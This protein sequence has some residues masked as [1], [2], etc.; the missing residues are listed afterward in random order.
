MA[1]AHCQPLPRG[2]AR[3]Q[4]LGT[5][6]QGR[7]GQPASLRRTA[8]A[9]TAAE[10]GAPSGRLARWRRAAV[11][12]TVTV[13]RELALLSRAAA[14]AAAAAAWLRRRLCLRPA[15][16]VAK[17]AAKAARASRR[18]VSVAAE[19]VPAERVLE[20]GIGTQQPFFEV[21]HRSA[22]SS[23]R[24]GRLH[25]PHGVVETP[26]FVPVATHGAI[27]A[28]S[29]SDATDLGAQLV[30][31]NTLH[32]LVHPG[33]EVVAGAGGLHRFSG[34][35]GPIITDS[36]GFQLFS[37][38]A[39]SAEDGPELKCRT[40][41]RAG[42]A[43][44]SPSLLRVSE[45]GAVFRSYFD[46]THID[47]SP[48]S[49]V[50]AQKQLGSDIILPLDWLTCQGSS[51]EHLL[52]ATERSHRWMARSLAEHRR[53]P[54]GQR[55]YGILHGGTDLALR[56]RSF[57]FCAARAFDGLAIGGSLGEDRADMERLLEAVM[58][59]L[60]EPLAANRPVHLL[61]IGDFDS[62]QRFAPLGIDTFDS[63][64]VTRI[65]RNGR[66]LVWSGRG[67]GP[68]PDR[69]V[70][71]NILRGR[72]RNDH[73]PIDSREVTVP[74]TRAYLH[75]LFK[76]W[77]PLAMAIATQHNLAM[78]FAAVAKLRADILADRV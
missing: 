47:L 51:A 12:Q 66:L 39:R 32:L 9:Q 8:V 72:F 25:T 52:E 67:D 59:W 53:A 2:L 50:Q 73:T 23:A 22:R 58:P 48:E 17:P 78:M 35:G 14:V 38:A 5:S 36:G 61:G 62:I 42:S 26:M 63:C 43:G 31:C 24:V 21:V 46:G 11:A 27:K 54:R 37:L 60:Q 19:D 71:L 49:T 69:L 30:F 7:S 28:V 55:M 75:H 56:R 44:R 18:W 15:K 74:Y 40:V 16:L 6:L 20:D 13:A 70:K 76:A 3:P 57:E 41:N 34:R 10:L 4:W 77:E 33:A 45:E 64:L 29:P 1:G 65:A 68:D